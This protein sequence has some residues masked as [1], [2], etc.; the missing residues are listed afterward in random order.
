MSLTAKLSMIVGVLL[1]ASVGLNVSLGRQVDAHRTCLAAIRPDAKLGA[2]PRKLCDP[3]TAARWARA[4]QAETCD[5]AFS[6]RPENRYG[7]ANNCSTA[8]KRVQAQRDAVSTELHGL[9]TELA[10]VRSNQTAAIR[11]AE[12]DARTQAERKLR[13]QAAVDRA[14]RT[15]DGRVH[16]DARCLRDR[17][18]SGDAHGPGG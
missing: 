15:A 1:L 8:V 7:V 18:G 4:V 11:R 17:Q 13:A 12:A 2:D 16:C 6:A 9:V 14:P 10:T 5:L 3:I